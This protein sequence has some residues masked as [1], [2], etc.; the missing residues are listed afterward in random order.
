MVYEKMNDVQLRTGRSIK[1]EEVNR[2]IDELDKTDLEETDKYVMKE[3]LRS[4]ERDIFFKTDLNDRQINA[5]GKA[6]A[7]NDIV[8][9]QSLWLKDNEAGQKDMDNVIVN[10]C[11]VMMKL[12]VSKN[13]RGRLEFIK[14]WIGGNDNNQNEKELNKYLNSDKIFK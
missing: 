12:V 1:D 14:A 11:N 13:R 10:L 9:A 3:L 7:V 6:L 2:L 5:I 4:S 8:N